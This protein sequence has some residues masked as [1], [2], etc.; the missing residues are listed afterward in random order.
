MEQLTA[1]LLPCCCQQWC[2]GMNPPLPTVMRSCYCFPQQIRLASC[3]VQPKLWRS[4]LRN[5][6]LPAVYTHVSARQELVI[7][8]FP[9]WLLTLLN[10]G[11]ALLTQE[12]SMSK[13][14]WR[15]TD[16]LTES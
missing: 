12:H 9:L 11:P 1:R 3:I 16:A 6:L 13:V 10:N 4:D 2:V 7:Q 5:L 15:F 14:R 8:I